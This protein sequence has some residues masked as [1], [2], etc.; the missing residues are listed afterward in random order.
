VL[1]NFSVAGL[2]AGFN[3]LIS[4]G[5]IIRHISNTMFKR[6]KQVPSWLNNPGILFV[7]AIW[8]SILDT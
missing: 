5:C 7:D 8:V 4:A 2:S 6:G 3:F 1:I